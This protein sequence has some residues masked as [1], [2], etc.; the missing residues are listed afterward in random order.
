MMHPAPFDNFSA[1]SA[2]GT[3]LAGRHWKPKNHKRGNIV[4]VHGFGEHLGRYDFLATG[5]SGA[6]FEVVGVDLRGHG[7][8]DG[9]RGF[10]H[11]WQ[12]YL[13]DVQ[14]AASRLDQDYFLLGHS[15]GG[16][17]TLEFVRQYPDA[18][19]GMILSSP[20]LGVAIP[21]PG[22]KEFLARHMSKWLPRLSL[23]A[24]LDPDWISR[25]SEDVAN[26]RNDPL[27]FDKVTPRWFVEMNA[28]LE[29]IHANAPRYRTPMLLHIGDADKIVSMS[30]ALRFT[31]AYSGPKNGQVWK[32]GYHE[33]F[34]DL[35]KDAVLAATLIWLD[36]QLGHSAPDQESA[37]S[38]SNS[39][40]A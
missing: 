8:S 13:T 34:H 36:K 29:R 1:R 12:D 39:N 21:T 23:P 9:Q 18:V 25:D 20:L 7:G 30:E 32:G 2:D 10:I 40:T 37:G 16:P 26:Y 4:L 6:G 33:L 27:I 35:E 24:G 3:R 14:A 19:Q 38:I 22:W 15:M 31:E 28:A 11:R 5:L 17:V